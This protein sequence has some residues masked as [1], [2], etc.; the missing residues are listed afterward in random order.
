M[1]DTFQFIIE[2]PQHNVGQKKR[3]R[4]V[5]SCDNWSVVPP[6]PPHLSDNSRPLQPSQENQVSPALSRRKM[7]GLQGRKDPVSLQGP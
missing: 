3:P 4:L 5:T 2:S 7:R 6:I 1:E